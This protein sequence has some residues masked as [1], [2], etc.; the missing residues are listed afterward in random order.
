MTRALQFLIITL[1]FI[2]LVR[3]LSAQDIPIGTWRVHISFYSLVDVMPTHSKVY[4]AAQ[5]GVIIINRQDNSIQFYHKGNGLHNTGVSQIAYDATSDQL[6]AAYADGTFDVIREN[7]IRFFDP[8]RNAVITG[9]KA[10]NSIYVHET[11]AYFSTDYGVLIYDLSRGEIKETWRDLGEGGSTIRVIASTIR[12]DSVFLATDTGIIAGTLTDNLLDFNKWKR[13]EEGNFLQTATSIATV[14]EVVYAASREGGVYAY[15]SGSWSKVEMLPDG[16][17]LKLTATA[18]K[19]ALTDGTNVWVLHPATNEAGIAYTDSESGVVKAA[20]DGTGVLW[21]ATKGSGLLTNETGSF[22]SIVP[23]GPAFNETVAL[24]YNAGKIIAVSGGFSADSEPL[25]KPGN[26]GIFE[27]G[28]WSSETLSASD[29]TSIAFNE[30]GRRF[31]GSFGFGLLDAEGEA[32]RV[33]DETN[34]SLINTERPGRSVDITSIANAADGLWVANYAAMPPLHFF[35]Y[36]DNT[37]ESYSFPYAN[38]RYPVKLHT[39]FRNDVWMA[40]DTERGGGLVVFDRVRNQH[41]TLSAQAGQGGLPS[42]RIYEV[43]SDRDGNVWVGTDAGV[44]YFFDKNSDAVKPIFEN[45]FLL[46]DETVHAIAVDGGNRKW[47]GTERGVWLFN[48]TGDQELANFTVENSPLP[49]NRIHDIEINSVSGEVFFA[50][51]RGIASFRSNA[52]GGGSNFQTV[53]IFPNPIMGTFAGDVGITGLAT[54][55][56]VKI[57]DISGRLIRETRAN[58][59]SASWD[60]RDYKGRRVDT[61]IYLVMAVAPDGSESIVGKIAVVN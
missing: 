47:I 50:T 31:I 21:I 38:A 58:G 8:A 18:D 13:F 12:G 1:H 20:L 24:R 16:I 43:M 29:L 25:N 56:I 11:M 39:D 9:S 7:R 51:D 2:A 40:L 28:I 59:G 35:N 23:N 15:Y 33:W 17:F 3:S 19:L 6:L 10:I 34:S 32:S 30:N 22:T 41:V 27:G 45:R 14:G 5:N 60:V 52:T 26:I 57:T 4:A 42:N 49:S 44:A 54:D 61:G 37:W 36:N 46:R 48:S 55:A 53:K